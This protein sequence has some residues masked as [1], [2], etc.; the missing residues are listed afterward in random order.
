MAD[1]FYTI[2]AVPVVLLSMVSQVQ[3]IVLH[4]GDTI[5]FSGVDII[6][7]EDKPVCRQSDGSTLPMS[8]Q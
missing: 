2:W 4:P 1:I 8:T 3:E 6:Y 5:S 7:A